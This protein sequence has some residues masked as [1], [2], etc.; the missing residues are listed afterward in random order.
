MAAWAQ[1][2]LV[3]LGA[4]LTALG[5]RLAYPR[6]RRDIAKRDESETIRSLRETL[7]A[8]IDARKARDDHHKFQM[9]ILAGEHARCREETADLRARLDA[10]AGKF[11]DDLAAKIVVAVEDKVAEI[12]GRA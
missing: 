4:V 3:A 8:E 5:L 1:I 9:E 11:A 12:V 2:A 6:L 7:D 10:M